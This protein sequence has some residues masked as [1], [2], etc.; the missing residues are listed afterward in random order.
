MPGHS[1]EMAIFQLTDRLPMYCYFD[2]AKPYF[3]SVVYV[4]MWS[5]DTNV[6]VL[7]DGLGQTVMS[8]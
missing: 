1:I 4:R 5:V 6:N 8:T 3:A 7:W 2:S